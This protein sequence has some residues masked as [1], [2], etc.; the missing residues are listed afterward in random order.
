MRGNGIWYLLL[1]GELFV[2]NLY[3]A[4][5]ELE[6]HCFV[7]RELHE[8]ILHLL[9]YFTKVNTYIYPP[10][11]TAAETAQSKSKRRR[12]RWHCSLRNWKNIHWSVGEDISFVIVLSVALFIST[13]VFC[14][15]W[16]QAHN[17]IW[18]IFIVNEPSL[19]LSWTIFTQYTSSHPISLR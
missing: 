8:T 5:Y 12:F 13:T 9:Y 1:L 18:I 10:P 14:L 15:L 4:A 16:S 2:V 3:D 19:F 11:F 7:P 17:H 6:V